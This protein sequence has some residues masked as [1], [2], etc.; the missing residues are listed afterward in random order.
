[1][2]VTDAFKIIADKGPLDRDPRMRVPHGAVYAAPTRWP[3]TPSAGSGDHEE[4][5]RLGMKTLAEAGL[6]PRY[7]RTAA[8]LGLGL[9]DLDRIR[10]TSVEF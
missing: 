9:H 8:D 7:I 1:L 3:W 5:R 10:M 6:T 4:R 2:H